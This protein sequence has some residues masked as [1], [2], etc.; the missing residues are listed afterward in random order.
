MQD[1]LDEQEQEEEIAALE[2]AAGGQAARTRT[3]MTAAGALLATAYLALAL[4]QALYPWQLL[5]AEMRA[6]E[7]SS[8]SLIVG[9]LGG[10]V[11]VLVALAAVLAFGRREEAAWRKLLSLSVT[12]ALFEAAFWGTVVVKL[13]MQPAYVRGELWRVLWLPL[14]PAGWVAAVVVVIDGM[15]KLGRQFGA[16]RAARYPLKRA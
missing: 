9:L 15:D 8:E 13:L 4:H 6:A 11:T 7:I 3:L 1:F 14:A 5:P 2:R 16:L 10:A 12:L